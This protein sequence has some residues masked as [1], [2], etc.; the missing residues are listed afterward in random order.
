MNSFADKTREELLSEI[1]RLQGELIAATHFNNPHILTKP[2]MSRIQEVFEHLDSEHNGFVTVSELA[3]LHLALGE[4]LTSKEI[5]NNMDLV[6]G[7]N[8]QGNI[9][10]NSFIT[11]WMNI[12]KSRRDW[13]TSRFKFQKGGIVRDESLLFVAQNI[14]TEASGEPGTLAYRLH[15]YYLEEGIKKHISP[16]HDI[17]LISHVK[18]G[19]TF[20]NMIVEI[21]KWTR[22]KFEITTGEPFNPIK[23]DVKN[24]ILR[25]YIW[26]DMYF[27]YGAF[28]QTW[29]DPNI[30]TADTG[31]KGDNDPL[32]VIEIGYRQFRTGGVVPVKIIGVLGMIDDGETDWKILAIS[33]DDLLAPRINDIPDLEREVPGLVCSIRE[34]LRVYKVCTGQ[35]ENSFALEERAMNKEYALSIIRDTHLHWKHL[36][37]KNSVQASS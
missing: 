23:Q 33:S 32:D 2:E 35:P 11:Y 3:K 10:F 21:P 26:G 5:A 28:P 6:G 20:Y 37:E 7:L 25:D 18:A 4:E 29:E 12:Q 17:P 34:W 36:Q 30:V 8:E 24:G 15:F 14:S 1:E 19:E 22:A 27:N 13:Y 16:W 31:Y 9:D